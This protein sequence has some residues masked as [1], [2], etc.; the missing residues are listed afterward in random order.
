[1]YIGSSLTVAIDGR[2]WTDR[3]RR[4]KC[5]AFKDAA[6]DIAMEDTRR[7]AFGGLGAGLPESGIVPM[8]ITL[9]VA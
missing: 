6:L 2:I 8:P 5:G 7:G 9:D 4:L 1:M 3:R